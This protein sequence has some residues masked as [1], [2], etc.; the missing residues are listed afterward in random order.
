MYSRI[1]NYD[2]DSG[3][4]DNITVFRNLG[5][6]VITTWKDS[7]GSWEM[8]GIN[9]TSTQLDRLYYQRMYILEYL[10]TLNNNYETKNNSYN[11]LSCVFSNFCPKD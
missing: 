11:T 1:I 5:W 9:V 7:C 3:L 6:S 10:L 4:L 2:G 8:D